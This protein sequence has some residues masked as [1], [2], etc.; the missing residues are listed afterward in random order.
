MGPE[1]GIRFEVRSYGSVSS[2]EV[3]LGKVLHPASQ[4]VI[5]VYL[6][7]RESVHSLVVGNNGSLRRTEG[8][9]SLE[10]RDDGAEFAVTGGPFL[11]ANREG[12]REL[13]DYAQAPGR[14]LREVPTPRYSGSV[15]LGEG[16]LGVVVANQDARADECLLNGPERLT[17]RI[18]TGTWPNL[19]RADK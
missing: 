2:G 15:G 14:G 17:R 7:P 16:R 13:G 9:S 6:H 11:L 5:P 18:R 12:A 10:P 8:D 3:E 4:G 1:E 19:F